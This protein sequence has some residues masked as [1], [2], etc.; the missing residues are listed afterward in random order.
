[1][2]G[3]PLAPKMA[4]LVVISGIKNPKPNTTGGL[5]FYLKISAS[6]GTKT[7]S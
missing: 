1:M 7:V 3:Y 4:Q 2:F 5:T 6:Y